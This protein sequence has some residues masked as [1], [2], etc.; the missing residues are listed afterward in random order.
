M[1]L[2][3]TYEQ[4]AEKYQFHKH[5][6]EGWEVVDFINELEPTLDRIMEYGQFYAE[7]YLKTKQALSEWIKNNLPYTTKAHRY[8]LKYFADKYNGMHILSGEKLKL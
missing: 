3:L 5:I 4:I 7:P 8:V 6:W 1:I 2:N